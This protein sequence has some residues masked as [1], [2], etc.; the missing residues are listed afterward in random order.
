MKTNPD[1]IRCEFVGTDARIARSSNRSHV[2]MAGKVVDETRNTFTIMREGKRKSIP[3]NSS[4]FDF[5]F[6]DGTVVEIDGKLLS[7]RPEDRLKKSIRRL[8]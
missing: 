6:S 8:W 4:I 3:K 5:T 7:G 1:I 2:G